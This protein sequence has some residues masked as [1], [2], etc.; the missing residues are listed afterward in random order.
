MSTAEIVRPPLLYSG[1]RLGRE[2]FF[3]R[4]DEWEASGRNV[5]GIERLEGVVYMP[6]AP[7]RMDQHGEPQAIIIS[8]LATYAAMTPGVQP[9]GSATSK[10]DDDNDPE[11]DAVLRIR[12]EFGGQSKTDAKGYIEGAPELLVEVTASTLPR[13]LQLKFEI[14]RRNGVREYL[15]WETIAEEFHWFALENGEY[16]RLVPDE[17]HVLRSRVFPGLWL[18]VHALLSGNL[19]R[20]LDFVRQGAASPEHAAFAAEL[21][22]RRVK[23]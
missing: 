15:V 3:R 9:A 2:E 13:D 16:V 21:E 5:R 7:I 19:A 1:Q 6:A 17:Q 18:D 20:V 23:S 12:P 10:L 14:Y 4:I 11:G 8:W 22:T